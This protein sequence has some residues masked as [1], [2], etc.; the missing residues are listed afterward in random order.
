MTP[1]H[2]Q[3]TAAVAA[4]AVVVLPAHTIATVI[5][6][7]CGAI[8]LGAAVSQ[9]ELNRPGVGRRNT[10]PFFRDA[11]SAENAFAKTA[12][13]STPSCAAKT[14]TVYR[15]ACATWRVWTAVMTAVG[16]ME[17][18]LAVA[19]VLS[20]TP[21]LPQPSCAALVSLPPPFPPIYIHA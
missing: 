3:H 17:E 1:L 16:E 8:L 4:A 12:S 2:R 9:H 13:P 14:V 5:P 19:V 18:R 21:V 7:C 20:L 15:A 10:L 11:L 6:G